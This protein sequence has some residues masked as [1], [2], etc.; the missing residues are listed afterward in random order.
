[1][2]ALTA[3]LLLL[4]SFSETP[5]AA[6]PS[7]SPPA[8]PP[9]SAS[10][11]SPVLLAPGVTLERQITP[12]ER[13]IAHFEL[14]TG[15]FV[16]L[17]VN[18]RFI[19]LTV[20]LRGPGGEQLVVQQS[21]AQRWEPERLSVVTESSGIHSV[22]IHATEPAKG[23]SRSVHLPGTYRLRI[24]EYR[25]TQPSD[26]LRLRAERLH[27]MGL[28]RFEEGTRTGFSA[29]LESFR[30]ALPMWQQTGHTR[31]EATERHW[32]ALVHYELDEP[33][34]AITNLD[35][36]LALWKGL[37]RDDF[38]AETLYR[39][40]SARAKHGDNSSALDDLSAALDLLSTD[41]DEGE[42]RGLT[43]NNRGYVEIQ[44]SELQRA[45]DTYHLALAEFRSLGIREQES[46]VLHNL[47]AV[48][49]R[50]GEFEEASRRF[51]E[52]LVLAEE[53]ADPLSQARSLNGIGW[54]YKAQGSPHLALPLFKKAIA[55]AEEVGNVR[56]QGAF[57]DN[58]ARALLDLGQPEAALT[59]ATRALKLSRLAED[60]RGEA[61]RLVTLGI[62]ERNLGERTLSLGVAEAAIHQDRSVTYLEEAHRLS[63]EIGERRNA[64]AA[65]TELARTLR[66]LDEFDR[67]LLA[68]EEA[69]RI[70]EAIRLGLNRESTR[71][72][73]LAFERG[74]WEFH[75]EL[76]MELDRRRPGEGWR[77]AALAASER[78]RARSLL[79]IL[80]TGD[81][82]DEVPA[83]LLER[84]RDLRDRLGVV[85]RR[86]L[87]RPGTPGASDEAEM[88]ALLDG[89]AQL[90]KDLRGTSRS[91][92]VRHPRLLSAYEIQQEV[93]DADSVLVEISLGEE[94]SY[95]WVVTSESVTALEL[96]PR[97]ELE[98]R[99]RRVHSLAADRRGWMGLSWRDHK[100]SFD[101]EAEALGRTLLAFLA[102][103]SRRRLLIV[104]EGALLL[105]PW[106]A[107][108]V[109]ATGEPLLRTHE[110]VLLPSA[111][112]A[113]SLRQR[114]P[115]PSKGEILILA[116][117]VFTA[118]D[119]RVIEGASGETEPPRTRP[120]AVPHRATLLRSA[121]DAGLETFPRL[122]A[123]RREAQAVAALVASPRLL[124]DFAASRETV[125]S[126][127]LERYT[128]LHF[129]TH[130]LVNPRRPELSGLVLSLVDAQGAP[131][132][133]FLRLIDLSTLDLT[134]ELV[135]LSACRTAL[136]KAVRG[137][138]LIGLVRG[139][140]DAGARRV[141]ATLW[142]VEDRATAELM[143]RF[144]RGILEGGLE[145]AAALRR[146]QLEL[147][148][149]AA[150][151]AWA[152]PF[153]WA[154]VVLAGEWQGWNRP[155]DAEE[156]RETPP[157]TH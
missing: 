74:A 100:E 54:G 114:P 128:I 34:A 127:D 117:P 4:F 2:S 144:Y 86:M 45:I 18:S 6:Q 103:V 11:P 16:S 85:A 149:G 14:Q 104:A 116:D 3:A 41:D 96:P 40:G 60:R 137:E 150:D 19:D 79:E 155:E 151:P 57:R 12:D 46:L 55:L 62:T 87:G 106:A 130:G 58:L 47:A 118:N 93:L 99:A 78:H 8:G 122:V 125:L 119:P 97:V 31:G 95:Q 35:I 43:L 15:L 126:E 73:Y 39:R 56:R 84:Q 26:P 72:A 101:R 42:R 94:R 153:F 44:T 147:I 23:E 133:G 67:A 82:W 13:Q 80:G 75:V 113:A 68:I 102:D 88:Q 66:A 1:M 129:A 9:V 146:S 52:A 22:E 33:K 111:S 64:A 131:R 10:L 27:A 124:M 70:V 142:Q 143:S 139:F 157:S 50:L 141:V 120:S 63:D 115:A 37:G 30:A 7:P 145:P 123:S 112:V 136:G 92:E 138:G 49:Q 152:A 109:P 132:D 53:L 38:I 71:A 36:A 77:E 28:T 156:V 17:Q 135:V 51:A 24:A 29:A 20:T 110:I 69:L 48:H 5:P 90:E 148:D 108:P 107:L 105:V 65:L 154:P 25:P 21:P 83:E 59:E 134:A 76:L 98:A 89:L 32:I 91:A 140:F 81:L 121:R 61:V